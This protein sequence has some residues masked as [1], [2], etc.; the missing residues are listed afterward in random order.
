MKLLSEGNPKIIKGEKYGYLTSI[1]HLAPHNSSGWNVCA[2][3]SDGCSK[4][5]LYYQGRGRMDNTKRARLEKTRMFFQEKERFMQQIAHEISLLAKR[6]PKKNMIPSVRLNG[7]SDIP[8]ERVRFG[9]NKLNIFEMF[10]DMQFYDYT[11][12]PD[13]RDLPSNYHLTFSLAEDNDEN[14]K[15][16]IQQGLNLAVVFRH[17]LPETFWG[18]P[19]FNGDDSDLRFLDP[20]NHII[21]LVAKG[22][23]VHDDSGFVR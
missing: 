16:A 22:T 21:G 2:N 15:L 17:E 14:A 11:K 23:A 12:R 4:A 13:R 10:P 1:L 3:A 8:W 7:T 9:D 18:L 6:A 19:V 5:C 20:A